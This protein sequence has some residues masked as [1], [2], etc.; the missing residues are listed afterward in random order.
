M[1]DRRRVANHEKRRPSVNESSSVALHI[2]RAGRVDV[3]TV[4]RIPIDWFYE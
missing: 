1:A 3:D 4:A 2:R